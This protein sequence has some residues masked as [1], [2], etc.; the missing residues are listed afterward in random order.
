MRSGMVMVWVRRESVRKLVV[1]VWYQM[2]VSTVKDRDISEM[3]GQQL[4]MPD[5]GNSRLTSHACLPHSHASLPLRVAAHSEYPFNI[6]LSILFSKH[7]S[8]IWQSLYATTTTKD[9]DGTTWREDGQTRTRVTG[10]HVWTRASDFPPFTVFA[11]HPGWR[12]ESDTSIPKLLTHSPTN[13]PFEGYP[14]NDG[15]RISS[16]I[17]K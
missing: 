9:D 17:T 5:G 1:S 10:Q 7:V 6:L 2:G 16:T 12:S 14:C 11:H 15:N 8:Y 4:R 3:P 13:K